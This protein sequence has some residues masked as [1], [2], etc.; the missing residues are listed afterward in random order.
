MPYLRP[1]YALITLIS[2]AYLF[3]VGCSQPHVGLSA[4]QFTGLHP[5]RS[6]VA[7]QNSESRAPAP[8]IDFKVAGKVPAIKQPESMACW[9]TAATIMISWKERK[10]YEIEEVVARAGKKYLAFYEANTGIDG[11]DKAEFLS[12]L[13]L[14]AEAPQTFT[15]KGWLWLLQNYGPLWV[16]SE[17][18]QGSKFSVHARIVIAI[19]GD[20]SIENTYLTIIDP[21]DGSEYRENIDEFTRKYENVGRTDLD[22]RKIDP[23][24]DLRPQ[25]VHF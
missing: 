3:S 21:Q 12:A 23:Q 17:D 19:S 6:Q 10:E 11:E 24:K 1:T 9:A 13:N 18:K 22:I 20:G 4:G 5:L 2:A 16:T 8:A 15:V 14:R 25:M 7:S